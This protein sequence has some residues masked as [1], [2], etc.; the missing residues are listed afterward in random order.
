[1]SL[2]FGLHQASN[3]ESVIDS[4][5]SLHS[6][7]TASIQ[8][9]KHLHIAL[10]TIDLKGSPLVAG[11]VYSYNIYFSSDSDLN[12]EGL[13]EDQEDHSPKRL[14]L[15][16]IPLQLPSFVLPGS[17]MSLR[18][19]IQPTR[20]A[21]ALQP[22]NPFSFTHPEKQPHLIRRQISRVQRPT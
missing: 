3:S 21:G 7:T 5:A 16:Y 13:L 17:K 11:G 9:G 18:N 15:G 2:W 14:A 4:S 12:T 8:I 10:I 6:A 19:C 1:M 22:K 20:T